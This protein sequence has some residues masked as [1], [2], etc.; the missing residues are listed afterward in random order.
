MDEVK[1]IRPTIDQVKKFFALFE[2]IGSC[3][4]DA[5]QSLLLNGGAQ[6]EDFD[7]PFRVDGEY[8]YIFHPEEVSIKDDSITQSYNEL[9]HYLIPMKEDDT[10]FLVNLSGSNDGEYSYRFIDVSFYRISDFNHVKNYIINNIASTHISRA[11]DILQKNLVGNDQIEKLRSL[12]ESSALGSAF[13]ADDN[14]R[15]LKD[16]TEHDDKP[17]A[18]I[19]RRGL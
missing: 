15:R 14:A 10:F 3:L 19:S 12:I 6:L 9:C 8:E 11:V 7:L 17:R 16:M 1:K 2:S 18:V 4:E 5:T 13:I